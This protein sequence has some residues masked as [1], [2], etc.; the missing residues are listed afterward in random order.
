M[1][2]ERLYAG[3]RDVFVTDLLPATALL[4]Q[5]FLPKVKSTSGHVVIRVSPGGG[6]FRVFV[7]DNNDESDRIKASHGPYACR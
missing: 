2:S 3:P 6:D 4:N 7:T 1:L 5:R